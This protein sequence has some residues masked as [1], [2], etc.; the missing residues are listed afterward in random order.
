MSASQLEERR[1]LG[2]GELLRACV[3]S[4]TRFPQDVLG[5]S[6]QSR[7][8]IVAQ[9]FSL[10][11]ETFLD[12]IEEGVFI[13]DG[14]FRARS[15]HA[16]TYER[17]GDFGRWPER[18]RRNPERDVRPAEPLRNYGEI[19]VIPASRLRHDSHR[20]LKLNYDMNCRDLFRVLEQA[21]Q[22]RRCD[23]VRQIAVCGKTL[24]AR[25][26]F[27]IDSHYIGFDHF[28]IFAGSSDFSQPP[29]KAR[30]E[31]NGEYFAG[32]LRETRGHF[33]VS[34]A[35]FHPQTTVDPNRMRDPL[36]PT[37]IGKEMLSKLL[38]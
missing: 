3:W 11:R 18:P 28:H 14:I 23:V 7:A 9:R 1:K 8:Q 24:A 38:R 33:P 20:D 13:A 36:L 27:K 19:P 30:V 21:M 26:F 2:D 25:Q 34:R 16:K 10:L 35:D 4:E 37:C 22:N 6:A 17:G 32:T 12:E 29:G 31:F 5:S 15:G